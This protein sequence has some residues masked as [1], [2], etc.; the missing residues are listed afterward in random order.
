MKK[1]APAAAGWRS[2]AFFLIGEL[3]ELETKCAPRAG[4]WD[5][6][7]EVTGAPGVHFEDYPQL[8]GFDAR[9][10]RASI[11]GTLARSPG[12]V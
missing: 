10:G 8:S 2:F 5:R 11:K 1:F 12:G 9:S 6:I 7:L 4:F 3:R